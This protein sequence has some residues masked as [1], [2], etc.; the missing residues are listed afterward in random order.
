MAGAASFL[1][2]SPDGIWP[3]PVLSAASRASKSLS[4]C[5]PSPSAAAAVCQFQGGA[6]GPPGPVSSAS[7]R[8]GWHV[9]KADLQVSK[10]G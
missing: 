5:A 2:L 1:R 8:P 7:S 4:V 9:A 6:K 3:L 10:S